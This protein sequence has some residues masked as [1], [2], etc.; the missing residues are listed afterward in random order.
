MTRLHTTTHFSIFLHIKQTNRETGCG[1]G[2]VFWRR[3]SDTAPMDYCTSPPPEPADASSSEWRRPPS[4]PE[5]PERRFGT[6][7]AVL[8]SGL[9]RQRIASR[10]RSGDLERRQH[11]CCVACDSGLRHVC[12]VSPAVLTLDAWGDHFV[13]CSRFVSLYF[14]G[15]CQKCLLLTRFGRFHWDYRH[16]DSQSVPHGNLFVRCALALRLLHGIHEFR[17]LRDERCWAR[18]PRLPFPIW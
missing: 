18:I 13:R 1:I 10:T 11:L 6:E 12:Q 14:K 16:F 5:A 7:R 9:S 17:P 2:P 4:L 15:V 3:T 8:N